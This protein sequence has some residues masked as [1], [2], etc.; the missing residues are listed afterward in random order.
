MPRQMFSYIVVACH[1]SL[2]F[3]VRFPPQLDLPHRVH[4][5]MTAAWEENKHRILGI[6]RIGNGQLLCRDIHNWSDVVGCMAV[7]MGRRQPVSWEL[8]VFKCMVGVG[9]GEGE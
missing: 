7:K 5:L 3:Q 4:E 6:D 9:G 8:Q 2:L 1:T